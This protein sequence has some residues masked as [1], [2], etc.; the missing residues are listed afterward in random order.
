MFSMFARSSIVL[1]PF[2]P[3]NFPK[4]SATPPSRAAQ[5]AWCLNEWTQCGNYGGPRCF[6]IAK[7]VNISPIKLLV[8]GL[9]HHF[10]FPIYGVSN[11]PN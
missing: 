8:G 9:E 10:Y 7:L 3:E 4:K 6:D 2:L 11:H 5:V 1:H